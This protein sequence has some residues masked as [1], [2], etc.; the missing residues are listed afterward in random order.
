MTDRVLTALPPE[1]ELSVP[2]ERCFDAQYGLEITSDDVA[3]GSV[4]ARVRV[5]EE[6]KQPLGIL[7]GGVLA[8]VAEALALRATYLA[9][10][11]RGKVTMGMENDTRFLHPILGGHV[12]ASARVRYRGDESWLWDVEHRD[13]EGQLCAA[14]R[15][16]IAIRSQGGPPERLT[17]PPWRRE[18]ERP[19]RPRDGASPGG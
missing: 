5:R 14:S 11:A 8:A 9:V 19:G 2:I 7:H 10:A 3:S 16:L 6:L 1:V 17:G 4:T 13:D 18:G 12:H 15:V